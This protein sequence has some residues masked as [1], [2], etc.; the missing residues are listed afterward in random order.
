MS[1]ANFY[2]SITFFLILNLNLMQTAT[3]I[4]QHIT[5]IFKILSDSSIQISSMSDFLQQAKWTFK[6]N[7]KG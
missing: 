3:E 2:P 5:S 1:I 4:F 6:S 7:K